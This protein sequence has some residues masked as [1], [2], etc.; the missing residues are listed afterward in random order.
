MTRYEFFRK[1]IAPLLFLGMVGL[2]AYDTC[3]KQERTHTKIVLDLG[4]AAAIVKRV[5]AELVVDQEVIGLFHR[6]ALPGSTI[7]PCKFEAAM[8]SP[9]G[10]LRIDVDLGTRQKTITRKIHA[11]EGSTVTVPLGDEL[12]PRTAAP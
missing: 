8:P 11:D 10:E 5:D 1:R 7:G 2:I 12:A 3:D 4:E 9:E 6:N